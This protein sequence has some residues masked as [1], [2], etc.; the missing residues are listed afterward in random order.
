VE[1][2]ALSELNEVAT[3]VQVEGFDQF[4]QVGVRFRLTLNTFEEIL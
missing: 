4:R 3:F 2:E 1:A